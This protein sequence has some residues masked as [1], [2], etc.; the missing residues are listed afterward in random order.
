MTGSHGPWCFREKPHGTVSS[1]AGMGSDFTGIVALALGV[2]CFS[3]P[4]EEG[5]EGGGKPSI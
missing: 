3:F 5:R 4:G 1:Q 2:L